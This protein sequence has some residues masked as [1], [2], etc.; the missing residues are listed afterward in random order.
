[1]LRI[2]AGKHRGR[3]IETKENATIRPTGSR[4]REAIFNILAHGEFRGL[5]RSPLVE[6]RVVDLFCGTGALGLEALSR[7]AAHVTFIDQSGDSISL[8]RANAAALGETSQSTQFLRSDSTSLP[9]TAKPCT[10]AFLDPP[11]NS[12]LAL[13]SLKSLDSQGWLLPGA[14]TVVEMDARENFVPPEFYTPFNER[15]YS[16]SKIVFLRYDKE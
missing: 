7:G 9:P 14:V 6:G 11:Y 2:I 13:K 5:G 10:L 4:T 1:M 8:A 16:N 12:G 15:K 3:R